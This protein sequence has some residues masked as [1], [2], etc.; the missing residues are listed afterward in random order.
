MRSSR[1]RGA[2]PGGLDGV[3]AVAQRLAAQPVGDAEGF[4]DR[5]RGGLVIAAGG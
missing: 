2:R 3:R 4:A 5:G 1:G